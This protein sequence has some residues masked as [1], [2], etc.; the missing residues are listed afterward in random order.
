VTRHGCQSECDD[1]K[2]SQQSG[3]AGSTPTDVVASSANTGAS[4]VIVKTV[5]NAVP[6]CSSGSCGGSNAAAASQ[7]SGS[8]ASVI[9]PAVGAQVAPT[10]ATATQPTVA[11]AAAVAQSAAAVASQSA[12][13]TASL[14]AAA[15]EASAAVQSTIANAQASAKQLLA[16][17]EAA[18][19]RLRSQGCRTGKCK[20]V[21][22]VMTPDRPASQAASMEASR[23]DRIFHAMELAKEYGMDG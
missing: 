2:D 8:A 7:Q 18:A 1:S 4:T 17:A 14:T 16:Q 21:I 23:D 15:N 6:L 9:A 19:S 13:A 11:A 12:A 5:S 10:Q 3:S 20:K 22:K